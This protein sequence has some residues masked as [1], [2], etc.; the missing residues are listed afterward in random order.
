[1]QTQTNVTLV[2]GV[3]YTVRRSVET[4]YQLQLQ[5][6][7]SGMWRMAYFRHGQLV[8]DMCC[9]AR[10]VSDATGEMLHQA[11][12]LLANG[13]TVAILARKRSVEF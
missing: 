6:S 3:P 11:R 7:A 12:M 10:N 2:A 8:P 1:M 4:D 9:L 5:R 13:H